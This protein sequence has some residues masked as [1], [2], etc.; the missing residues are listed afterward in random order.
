M[1]TRIDLRK[2]LHVYSAL[3]GS[4]FDYSFF[5]V[6]SVCENSLG[7]VQRIQNRAIRCIYKLDWDSPTK[8]P[9]SNQWSNMLK[10][11]SCN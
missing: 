4:I 8:D 1:L 5:T 9:F 11:G 10:K 2:L 6:A 3:I 7:L